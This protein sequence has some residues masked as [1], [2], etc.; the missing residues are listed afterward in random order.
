MQLS[1]DLRSKHNDEVDALE[2]NGCMY[3]AHCHST[4]SHVHID[5]EGLENVNGEMKEADS[6]MMQEE[7]NNSV[8]VVS[9][10]EKNKRKKVT[11]G[12]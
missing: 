10:K 5:L 4:L 8:S 2:E 6:K 11:L 7:I 12:D 9:K 3:I 1:Y